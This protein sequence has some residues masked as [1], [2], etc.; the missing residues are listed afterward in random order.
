MLIGEV[1]QAI[2]NFALL[3]GLRQRV[4]SPFDTICNGTGDGNAVLSGA[5]SSLSSRS[6]RKV[7]IAFSL[8]LWNAD[9]FLECLVAVARV[10]QT[11][12]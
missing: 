4:D 11:G 12:S 8:F 9:I 5:V 10:H 7:P 3:R 1:F 2:L 6:L